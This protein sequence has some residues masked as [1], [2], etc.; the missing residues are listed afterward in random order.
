[1][2]DEESGC[3]GQKNCRPYYYTRTRLDGQRGSTFIRFTT[4]SQQHNHDVVIPPDHGGCC[5]YSSDE[6]ASQRPPL[7]PVHRHR[8]DRM[9]RLEGSVTSIV[10]AV[11][12]M[13]R[14]GS[15][16][17]ARCSPAAGKRVP[18]Q[19]SSPVREIVDVG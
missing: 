13:R 4:V 16:A 8:R 6:P 18:V 5:P 2:T 10:R 3:W 1:M 19:P 12:R 15:R 7:L 17:R 14:L 11:V 9:S